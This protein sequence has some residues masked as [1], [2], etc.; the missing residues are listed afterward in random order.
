MSRQRDCCDWTIS[1]SDLYTFHTTTPLHKTVEISLNTAM[2]TLSEKGCVDWTLA[3]QFNKHIIDFT[4]ILAFL[5][6]EC[7]I[8]RFGGI[9]LL[10][11]WF[12]L[13]TF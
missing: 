13:I 8:H 6:E 11:R 2:P 1:V 4:L 5:V 3:I 7:I 9:D 10:W 12:F